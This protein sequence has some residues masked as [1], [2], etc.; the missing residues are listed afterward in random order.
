MLV[1]ERALRAAGYRTLAGL[2]EAGRGPL[3]GPVVAAAV[4]LPWDRPITRVRD[5]KQIPP[6]ERERLCHEILERATA[7]GLG[8]VGVRDIERLN[9]FQ[10]T[11]LAMEL[12][13]TRL[14]DRPDA[15]LI[16]AMSLRRIDVP[17]RAI[18]RGDRASYLIA[19]AS[20]VAK[21]TR[22]RLMD[23][24]HARYPVFGFDAHRGYGTLYHRHQLARRGGCAIH[25]RT[26]R[27]TAAGT[28]SD[29]Q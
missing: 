14:S 2:D 13:V 28:G 25:R 16:D 4:V 6:I 9:I 23:D 26:F 1:H 27:W 24:Y 7:V 3:A 21:V 11:V 19:A 5:S 17:Q 8:I 20:I 22:D 18:V 12:A 29:A 10:A 15:L